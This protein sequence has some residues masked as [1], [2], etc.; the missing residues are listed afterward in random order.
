MTVTEARRF[1]LRMM[2]PASMKRDRATE[3]QV[4]S[5]RYR[6]VQALD[7]I[8]DARLATG[9]MA[10]ALI[11]QGLTRAAV[12]ERLGVKKSYLNKALSEARAVASASILT[13]FEPVA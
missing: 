2:I 11:T 3:R 10:L 13:T 6:G 7:G 1:D 5:R 8:Q 12:M 9:R 4:K